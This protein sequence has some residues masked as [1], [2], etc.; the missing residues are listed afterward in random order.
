MTTTKHKNTNERAESLKSLNWLATGG[1]L[2]PATTESGR[3]DMPIC[4]WP[5]DHQLGADR[6]AIA[7]I[8]LASA[9]GLLKSLSEKRTDS[10]AAYFRAEA[11]RSKTWFSDS[12]TRLA[13]QVIL[14]GLINEPRKRG[15]PKA[16]VSPL[17]TAFLGGL[18][19]APGNGIFAALS[20]RGRPQEYTPDFLLKLARTVDEAKATLRGGGTRHVTEREGVERMVRDFLRRTGTAVKSQRDFREEIRMWCNLL[21]RA[22]KLE[23]E[24]HK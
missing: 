2:F 18:A 24:N 15:R 5:G 9:V 20:R 4:G 21:K 10:T 8:Y 16:F 11:E 14:Y 7:E 22:R 17:R 1:L 13:A 19:G 23:R 3:N 6:A 12:L